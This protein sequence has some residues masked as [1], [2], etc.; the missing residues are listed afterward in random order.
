MQ[1][2]DKGLVGLGRAIISKSRLSNAM[3]VPLV[4]VVVVFLGSL[5]GIIATGKDFFFW[6]MLII[7]IFF[8]VAFLYMLIVKP[9]LLRT[10]EHEERMLQL[11]A[12]MG[13]K[14]EELPESLIYDLPS[15]SPEDVKT[16]KAIDREAR[17]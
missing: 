16:P 3:G 13:Q 14:G 2:K 12:G 4:F 8:I 9:E 11:S 17:K 6:L 7:V 15:S 1:E 10:E 5:A